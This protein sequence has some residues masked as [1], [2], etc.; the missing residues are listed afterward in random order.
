MIFEMNNMVKRRK[1]REI[2]SEILKALSQ[3]PKSINEVAK[4]INSS[5]LTARRHLRWLEYR[6]VEKMVDKPR[7]K[8]YR[9]KVD[10]T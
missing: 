8:L 10:R 7:W 3:G 5:W 2:R 4:S 1:Y 9:L 6:K